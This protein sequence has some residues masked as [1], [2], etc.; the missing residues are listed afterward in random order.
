MSL[1][2][3]FGGTTAGAGIETLSQITVESLTGVPDI[4]CY[5]ATEGLGHQGKLR[6]YLMKVM[7]QP[8]PSR[9]M[10]K[11]LRKLECGIKANL[12]IWTSAGRSGGLRV[13][14][15]HIM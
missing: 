14:C 5:K 13:I 3:D 10:Y 1:L 6:L 12:R 2:G 7:T 11:A 9:P 4:T 8:I 15:Q